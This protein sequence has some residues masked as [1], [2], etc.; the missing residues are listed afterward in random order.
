MLLCCA[1]RSEGEMRRV[2]DAGCQV[3]SWL[4]FGGKQSVNERKFAAAPEK[5]FSLVWK[6]K[7]FGEVGENAENGR[8]V[9]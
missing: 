3:F 7:T 6:Q 5:I 8:V 4:G 2:S 1:V 9:M